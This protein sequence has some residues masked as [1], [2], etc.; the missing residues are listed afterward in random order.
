[1]LPFGLGEYVEGALKPHV[2]YARRQGISLAV[3]TVFG[4]A[5][6]L[7]LL[8][9]LFFALLY[10]MPPLV[11]ALLCALICL[12]VVAVAMS[13]VQRRARLRRIAGS[14]AV[15]VR[16]GKAAEVALGRMGA[17]RGFLGA[18][19][20]TLALGAVAFLIGRRSGD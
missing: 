14:E 16:E 11:A 5:A 4:I 6:V 19:L 8:M 15:A 7:F 2:I 12:T 3:V 13:A 18:V 20:P 9:A 1:M 10:V 17:L